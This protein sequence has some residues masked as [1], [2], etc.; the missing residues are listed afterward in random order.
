MC[1]TKSRRENTSDFRIIFCCV[2]M[3]L[4]NRKCTFSTT[5]AHTTVYIS[6]YC[7][8]HS[9][10][11][12]RAAHTMCA[13]AYNAVATLCH[14]ASIIGF[15]AGERLASFLCVNLTLSL[16]HIHTR[17]HVCT[18]AHTYTYIFFLRLFFFDH[19]EN[20]TTFWILKKME[21]SNT[22]SLNERE[23]ER[24]RVLIF[25]ENISKRI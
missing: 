20:L 23:R 6:R 18:R 15:P 4:Q 8:M 19:V 9:R 24:D 13:R 1:E 22:T 14:V 3:R 2:G 5:V 25:F 12:Y 11:S 16:S 21:I 17:T 7:S 10:C